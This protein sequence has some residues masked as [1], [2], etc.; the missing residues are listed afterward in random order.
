MSTVFERFGA[1]FCRLAGFAEPPVSRNGGEHPAFTLRIRGVDITFVDASHN[2]RHVVLVV[3]ELGEPPPDDA[4]QAWAALLEANRAVLPADGPRFS[5]NAHT[6]EAL[7]QWRFDG[8]EAFISDVFQRVL[9]L[10]DVALGWQRDCLSTSALTNLL[11][12]A[13]ASPG[14]RPANDA[15]AAGGASRFADLYE[16]LCR[17]TSRPSMQP[18]PDSPNAVQTRFFR[19]KVAGIDTTFAHFPQIAP[20]IC[21]A[22]LSFGKSSLQDAGSIART[23]LDSNFMMISQPHGALFHLHP[24]TGEIHLRY[25]LSLSDTDAGSCLTQLSNLTPFVVQ[26]KAIANSEAASAQPAS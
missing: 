13:Q 6:G 1:E 20:D 14:A 4:D 8:A 18:P 23:M 2:G 11:A 19:V 21:V 12:I 16:Q 26:W 22:G 15:A 7:L 25:A 17:T 9:R 24:P 3:A 5:R 10:A